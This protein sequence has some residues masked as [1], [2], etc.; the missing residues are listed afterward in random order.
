MSSPTNDT[1]E[2]DPNIL[3]CFPLI[4]RFLYF[5][6]YHHRYPKNQQSRHHLS[7]LYDVNLRHRF[8]SL[9]TFY[10]SWSYLHEWNRAYAS[11]PIKNPS[12]R[13]QVLTTFTNPPHPLPIADLQASF[14]SSSSQ[15]GS[16]ADPHP[17]HC[18]S[19]AE[20]HRRIYNSLAAPTSS[21]LIEFIACVLLGSPPSLHMCR[22]AWLLCLPSNL[23]QN[24]YLKVCSPKVAIW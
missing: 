21:M 8:Q 23:Q 14:V 6:Y 10:F 7:T 22:H 4:L 20:I 11:P 3:V 16:D 18:L 15:L 13:L 5:S 2:I 17:H 9:S 1:S 24:W 19:I 12:H